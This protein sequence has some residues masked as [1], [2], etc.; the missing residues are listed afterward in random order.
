LGKGACLI[1]TALNALT[2]GPRQ[3]EKRGRCFE[4]CGKS[5]WQIPSSDLK[6]LLL[7]LDPE[8]GVRNV[9]F[10]TLFNSA[11]T[12]AKAISKYLTYPASTTL[13]PPFSHHSHARKL[14]SIFPLAPA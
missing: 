8:L 9:L 1:N 3:A 7:Q 10:P 11:A 13:F 6:S 12:T 14:N 5:P 4:W 2:S